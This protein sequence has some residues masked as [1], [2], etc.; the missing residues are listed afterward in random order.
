M[1]YLQL[2]PKADFV[3]QL[4]NLMNKLLVKLSLR[5]D[6]VESFFEEKTEPFV[7]NFQG[8]FYTLRATDWTKDS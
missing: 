3:V 6:K 4:T 5:I 8:S 7:A 1:A 2:Q